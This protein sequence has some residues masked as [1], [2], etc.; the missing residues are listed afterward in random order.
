MKKEI[1]ILFSTPM[2]QAI[3][4]GRKTMTRRIVKPQPTFDTFLLA[5]I[6]RPSKNKLVSASHHFNA[7][8][9]EKMLPYSPYGKAGDLLW[10]RETLFQHGELGVSYVADNEWIDED[11]LTE[12]YKVYRDYAHCK[13]P[14]IHMQKMVARIWLEVT[15]VRVERLRDISEKD[16]IA[17]G[18]EIEP[19]SGYNQLN[20]PDPKYM[21]KKYDYPKGYKGQRSTMLVPIESFKSLWRSINGYD[22]WEA[23]PW[24]WVVSFK[25]LSTTGKPTEKPSFNFRSRNNLETSHF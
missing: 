1:P 16:A 21:G 4:Q 6:W 13:V 17:E 2:V 7:K 3:L 10:V 22:S 8:I 15:D 23:N 18:I 25:V 19:C 9:E 11:I 14:N 12:D 20:P 5:D 24:V